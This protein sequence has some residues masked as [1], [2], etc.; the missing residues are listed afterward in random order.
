MSTQFSA[1]C[2][3]ALRAHARAITGSLPLRPIP[4]LAA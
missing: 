2:A 1:L 4:I 3:V